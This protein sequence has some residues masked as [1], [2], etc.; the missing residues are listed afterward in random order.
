MA[1]LNF[2]DPSE[3]PW[4]SP[5]G[6]VYTFI[7][8]GINGYWS[9]TELDASTSIE[10]VFVE[11]A[12]DDMSGDLT[13]G[14]NKIKLDAST[15]AGTFAD[16]VDTRGGFTVDGGTSLSSGIYYRNDAGDKGLRL[17]SGSTVDADKTVEILTSG[18]ATFA[19][20]VVSGLSPLDGAGVGAALGPGY[21]NATRANANESVWRSF[22]QG[23]NDATVDITA[24][25]SAE[26][27][28]DVLSGESAANGVLIRGSDPAI[29]MSDTDSSGSAAYIGRTGTGSSAYQSYQLTDRNGANTVLLKGD[30]SG[31]FTGNVVAQNADGQVALFPNG[32][33]RTYSLAVD[34]NT[35]LFE[36]GSGAN[37]NNVFRVTSNGYCYA[38]NTSVGGLKATPDSGGFSVSNGVSGYARFAKTSIASAVVG[39][40]YTAG[41]RVWCGVNSL[42]TPTSEILEDG[43]AF[44]N[45]QVQVNSDLRKSTAAGV[46]KLA[47]LD[48]SLRLFNTPATYDDWRIKLKTDGS[49][50]FKGTVTSN[51]S[52]LTRAAGDLD[53]GE[54]L[55]KADTALKALKV[56]AA[57][58][59]DFTALKSA[60]ATAL[61]DI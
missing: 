41:G 46:L 13:L 14:T 57:A 29:K 61:A 8:S 12:G 10:A 55:E 23:S 9:G 17:Y 56:A 24:A 28:S 54:R 34:S 31:T 47:V 48:D 15:G 7:G 18:A 43:Q 58:A 5:T 25:G 39:L 4:L 35:N 53:V 37:N 33:C 52:I 1:K 27:A 45:G 42:G 3:S 6:V 30:G 36:G 60:I 19:S 59:S 40:N 21:V 32:R 22:I 50:D 20:N 16:R 11:V 2:P 51:G 44:F 49:A 26:F 38:N